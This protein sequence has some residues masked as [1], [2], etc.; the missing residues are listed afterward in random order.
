MTELNNLPH[1]CEKSG[2][3]RPDKIREAQVLVFFGFFSEDDDKILSSFRRSWFVLSQRVNHSSALGLE[4]LPVVGQKET[5]ERPKWCC[6]IF[7]L[8]P[9][10]SLQKED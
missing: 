10:P 5:G 9:L 4:N 1:T 2:K 7:P 6:I 8:P 3:M